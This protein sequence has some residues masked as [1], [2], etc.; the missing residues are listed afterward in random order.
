MATRRPRSPPPPRSH[1]PIS[2]A[3]EL[4][5]DRWTLLVVRD[6]LLKDK[7]YFRE[8][9]ESDEGIATNVLTDRLGNLIAHGIVTRVPDPQDRRNVRYDLTAKGRDLAPIL[10][11][12]IRWSGKHDPQTL[13]PRAYLRRIERDRERLVAELLEPRRR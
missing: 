12:L 4:L 11:E 9:A 3:L 8:F 6:L 13:A 10:V 5:G 2:F 7:H 1:C